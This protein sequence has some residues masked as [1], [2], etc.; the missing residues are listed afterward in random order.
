[1]AFRTSEELALRVLAVDD[2]ELDDDP[3]SQ[4]DAMEV[5]HNKR[6][7]EFLE[8]LSPEQVVQFVDNSS[9]TTQQI[10]SVRPFCPATTLTDREIALFARMKCLDP[11]QTPMSDCPE[12]G[13]RNTYDHDQTCS[14]KT[15]NRTARH[16]AVKKKVLFNAVK[17]SQHGARTSYETEIVLPQRHYHH[18]PELKIDVRIVG[19]AAMNGIGMDTDISFTT[20]STGRNKARANSAASN[21]KAQLY[22]ADKMKF[23][24]EM[25]KEFLEARA[26]KKRSKYSER[27]GYPF[28]PLIIS[29]GGWL[30]HQF[31]DFVVHLKGKK[32]LR[33][34]Y[35]ELAVGILRARTINLQLY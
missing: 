5:V 10:L 9:K 2:A 16:E 20:V 6:R 25:I 26:A 13:G 33:S 15:R 7:Q 32:F 24:E 12:C 19:E 27:A 1:V 3:P 34:F 11:Q 29:A 22:A 17:S 8:T 28:V 18:E 30:H 23:G 4:R 35:Q 31:Y 21:D 14:A